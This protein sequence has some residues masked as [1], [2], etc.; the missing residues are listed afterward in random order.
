MSK[1]E[2]ELRDFDIEA[3][4]NSDPDLVQ[5]NK[6]LQRIKSAGMLTISPEL[7]EKVPIFA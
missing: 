1:S 3:Q 7:F 6:E 4:N 2:D 5:Q